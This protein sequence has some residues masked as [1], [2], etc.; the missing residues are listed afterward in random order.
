MVRVGPWPA[1]TSVRW[2]KPAPTLRTSELTP[3]SHVALPG[4]A[5]TDVASFVLSMGPMATAAPV[6][7]MSTA[8]PALRPARPMKVPSV[9]GLVMSTPWLSCTVHW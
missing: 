9:F 6:A 3:A 4:R 8:G 5:M 1:T 2:R 7:D